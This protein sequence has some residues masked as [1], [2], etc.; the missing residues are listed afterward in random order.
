MDEANP[1]DTSQQ[2]E[3]DQS[4]QEESHYPPKKSDLPPLARYI[5]FM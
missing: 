3:N 4:T 1:A 5:V 2:S